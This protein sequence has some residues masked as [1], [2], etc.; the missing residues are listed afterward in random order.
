[1]I[2]PA[3]IFDVGSMTTMYLTKFSDIM[4]SKEVSPPRVGCFVLPCMRGCFNHMTQQWPYKISNLCNT[5]VSQ[6][7]ISDDATKQTSKT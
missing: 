4:T 6:Q 2:A 1:M 7:Y 3:Y 5:H